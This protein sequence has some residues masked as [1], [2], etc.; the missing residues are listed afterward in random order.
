[1]IN[2]IVRRLLLV[3]VLLFGVSVLI[4]LMLQALSPVERSALYVRDIPKNERALDSIIRQYGLD[5]PIYVQY[6]K[7]L[8]SEIFKT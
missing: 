2:Y 4:F 8:F 5:Q 7:W 3:P 6:W 1:M